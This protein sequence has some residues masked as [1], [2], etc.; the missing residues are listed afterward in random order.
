[1]FDDVT[2]ENICALNDNMK[3]IVRAKLQKAA[4]RIL[5]AEHVNLYGVGMG[6]AIALAAKYKFAKL[7]IRCS[8]EIDMYF[9]RIFAALVSKN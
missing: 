7:G 5:E 2:A 1:M 6:L 8:A 9:K 4:I 3:V